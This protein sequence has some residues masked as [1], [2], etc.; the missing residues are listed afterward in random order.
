[1]QLRPV[2]GGTPSER[3]IIFVMHDSEAL[4]VGARLLRANPGDISRTVTRRDGGGNA[5]RLTVTLDPQRDRRTG[6]GYVISAAGVRSDHRHTQDA[7]DSGRESQYDP[8]W[9]ADAEV[10]GDGW[11]AEMR[12]PFSQLRFPPSARPQWGLQIERWMPDRNED[13]QWVLIPLNE[14]GFIS[15]FATLEGL[16]GVRADR[17]IELVPYIA[18]D[19]TRRANATAANPL[20]HP[21]DGRV[22]V[23]AKFAVGSSLTLDAT[24]NPDFGQVEADPAEVN[25]SAFETFFD[26]RR[27]FFTEGS[28]LLRGTGAQYFYSR[29]IGAPPH[30]SVSGD[31]IDMPRSSTI[32]GAAKLT[33]RLPS[34]LSVGGLLAVTAAEHGRAHF[35]DSAVTQRLAV[36]PRTAY[37]LLRLQQELGSQASTLGAAITAVRRDFSGEDRLSSYLPR[38]AYYAGTDW[39]LR[40]QQ[41]KYAISGFA[42]VSH[43]AGDTG[44]I[45]RVQKSSVRFFQRPDATHL[46]FDPARQSLTGY[47]ASLRAD[48]DAGRHVLWGAQVTVE[49]PEYE[50]NDFGR[51]ASGDDIEYNAD[52]QFRETQ[53]GAVFRNWQLGFETRGGWN[54]A[55]MLLSNVWTQNTSLTF[56]NFWN[57]NV[58]T[59]FELPTIADHLT[60]GGPYMANAGERRHEARLSSPSGARTGWRIG[61]SYAR[62]ELQAVRTSVG[63]MVTFRPQPRWSLSLEPNYQK[64]AESRQYVT[65]VA[66]GSNTFGTRYVFAWIDRTTISTRMRLNYAFSAALTLEGYAEP[67]LASGVYSQF[68]ELAAA[69]RLDLRAYGSDGTTLAVDA[70]GNR[71]ITDGRDA[72]SLGNPDF[73]VRSFRSNVVMRWEWNPGSTL[74]LVW[75]QNRRTSESL[76]DPVRYYQLFRTARVAGDN[77]VSLKVSYWLPVRL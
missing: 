27:P 29:R 52:L 41:G 19:A 70:D 56:R 44:S 8:V 23:D 3:T 2:E 6:V 73:H 39:R 22:G 33:G 46:T 24:I 53:P 76:G 36:E 67:F 77:F 28:E 69:R 62:D 59:T 1:M 16:D 4:Y 15:R 64:G 17:P 49:S 51:L 58:R 34:R 57:A 66:G 18:G 12:I 10:T 35:V 26:E 71:N 50:V 72:F 68:G 65:Q 32:L 37:A 61:G 48:K 43:V 54:Y 40:F 55:G 74:F 7:R 47:T 14:T 38:E 21:Y 60:R 75:Q 13:V 42:G 11:T 45:S 9:S 31:F 20:V 25:L 5:E 30:V 63:G